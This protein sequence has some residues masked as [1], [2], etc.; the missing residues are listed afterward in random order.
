[1]LKIKA[2]TVMISAVAFA[3]A[4][5]AGLMA[6]GRP[7]IKNIDSKGGNII[8]FGDSITWGYG[9]KSGEDYPSGL[10][11]M[12]NQPVINAGVDGDTSVEGLKRFNTDVLKRNP[13]L[14]VIELGGNDFLRKISKEKTL[15]NIEKM[16]EQAQENGAMVAI[17][18]VSAGPFL[19][20][21]RIALQKV[22][23]KKGAIFI[24][25]VLSRI[26]ASPPLKSDFIHP[27]G[28]GYK[29]V[30]SRIY[31]AIIPYL[32][33]NVMIRKSAKKQK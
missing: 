24:P 25:G 16:I 31:R 21:Y 3:A 22:A 4:G 32:N 1:M 26:I 18:D 2:N 28:D 13:L 11:K 29:L 23:Y 27:N 15:S 20:D 30:A 17:F 33:K 7:E 8:C 10:A 5:I 14:V 6:L 19:R 9:A 12:L